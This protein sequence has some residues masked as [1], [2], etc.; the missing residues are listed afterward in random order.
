MTDTEIRKPGRPRSAQADQAILMA[1]LELI[2]EDGIH[3]MSLEGVAARAGVGKTTI[4]RRWPNK[5]ALVL[6]ALRQIKQPVVTFDTGNLRGD[7]AR[8]LHFLQRLLDDP[9][10]QRVTL[11]LLGEVAGRPEWSQHYFSDAVSANYAGFQ[12]MID[13]A[14]ERGELRADADTQLVM[15]LI[16]GPLFYHFLLSS[17]QPGRPAF[18]IERAVEMLWEGLQPYRANSE[19]D[20]ASA[21]R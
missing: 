21:T 7:I 5:D 13:R 9:L 17:F 16:G 2:A 14:R 12:G 20:A 19:S 15:D 4:Y 8:F 3:G 18:D 10:I 11:R 6:D 1:T